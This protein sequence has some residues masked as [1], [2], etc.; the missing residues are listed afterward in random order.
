MSRIGARRVRRFVQ[1]E[2][3]MFNPRL[4][5]ALWLCR[6]APPH[7]LVRSRVRILRLAG[8]GVGAATTI[9]GEIR[10]EG[11]PPRNL[12]I[13]SEC[14]INA[15]CVFDVADRIDIGDTVSMAQDVMILTST[16]QLGDSLNRAGPLTTAPVEIGSATWIGARSV[17]L[18]GVKIGKACIIASGSVVNRDVPPNSLIGGVPARLI[19][20]LDP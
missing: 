5:A 18:P 20:R 15:G 9:G 1:D 12:R 6:V 17:V 13:G 14:W 7:V 19:R 10:V 11:G 16:H 8:L 2:F 4:T 3:R